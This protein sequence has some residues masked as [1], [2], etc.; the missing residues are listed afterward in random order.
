[1]GGTRAGRRCVGLFVVALLVVAVPASAATVTFGPFSTVAVGS[2]PEAVAIGDVTGDGRSDV[3][4]TTS[5]ASDPA[6]DYRLWVLAQ[7]AE[8]SFA[9]PVSY[10]T[11]G[12]Y[13][14]RP[15]SVAIGDITGDG[16][17]DVVVGLARLGVQ[18]FPQL[19]G[20]SLGA[21]TFT[22]T[23]DASKV[24]L[25][26]LDADLQLDVA[27]VGWATNT[28]SV[29]LNDGAGGLR[30]PVSYSAQHAGYE[31]FE[32]ED[33]T[34]D[35]RDD[36]VVMSGQSYAV[37]NVSVLAQLA[38][39]GFA[40]ALEYRVASNVN[41]NGIGV[42][43]VTGDGRADVVASYGGNRPNSF[44]AVLA[45]TAAGSLGAPVSYPSY[46][47]P[48]PVEAAD[49]DLDG[50]ADVVTLH[51]GWTN[52]G[53]YLQT[54]GGLG[55]E[56]LA[57]IPYASHYNPHGLAVGDVNSDGSPDI[58][59]ADY[60]HGLVVLPGSATS[61]P[62]PPPTQPTADLGVDVGGAATSVKQRQTFTFFVNV[63]NTGPD[64]SK[65]SLVTDLAGLVSGL[66][67]DTAGCT[68]SALRISC[69][70]GSLASGGTTTV[71]VSGIATR[72]GTVVATATVDADLADLNTAND[73]DS[74]SIQIR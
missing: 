47:I 1:M 37:P 56:S 12:S 18:V 7:T 65:F 10:S 6:N 61:P 27:G 19:A 45:Q 33:V 3:V 4:M 24:R 16:A 49:V 26:H 46:D 52:A 59:V 54:D 13:G 67:S 66:K 31:D 57:P 8:G 34:G 39:G 63:T 73:T 72:K 41:T 36:L 69:S 15:E 23:G 11:A 44:V 5:F 71:R 51:G 70:L 22:S 64:A 55:T 62:P 9:A 28:V 38:G 2:W 50:R 14:Q 48:E 68:A 21:P 20:G 43:D 30:P 40:S 53:I 60:N 74:A 32:V 42:G 35:G 29:L 25:G 58:V 17:A